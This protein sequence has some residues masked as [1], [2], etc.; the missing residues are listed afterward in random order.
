MTERIRL[1]HGLEPAIDYSVKDKWLHFPKSRYRNSV[2]SRELLR[3]VTRV[4]N[5]FTADGFLIILVSI[6]CLCPTPTLTDEEF[7]D[8]DRE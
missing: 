2:V 6:E 5:T 7:G 8:I 3:F 4:R 1:R